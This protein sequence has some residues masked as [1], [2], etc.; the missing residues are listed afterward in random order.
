MRLSVAGLA[1]AAGV[2][3]VGAGAAIVATDAEDAKEVTTVVEDAKEVVVEVADVKL[4]EAKAV[5]MDNY[6]SAVAGIP[7]LQAAGVTG[8]QVKRVC[9][10]WW[11]KGD[12][13]E[14]IT[15]RETVHKCEIPDEELPN[16]AFRK[17]VGMRCD[18]VDSFSF[19]AL[20]WTCPAECSCMTVCARIRR[21]KS[22]A[23]LMDDLVNCLLEVCAPCDVRPDDWDQCPWCLAPG[24]DC[25]TECR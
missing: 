23:H 2:A 18:G 19:R 3:L 8:D 16:A 9:L 21:T 12:Y 5:D 10:L 13:L 24:H 17:Y 4:T 25:A 15:D 11:A 14:C 1:M 7:C 6:R 20:S 22:M